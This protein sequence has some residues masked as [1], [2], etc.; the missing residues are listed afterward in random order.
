MLISRTALVLMGL[1]VGVS[2]QAQCDI[3]L[4]RA[5]FITC[6]SL[7]QQQ[8][9]GVYP[10]PSQ[11]QAPVLQA[12]QPLYQQPAPIYQQPAPLY[13]AP[14]AIYQPPAPIYQQPPIQ[15]VP[16]NRSSAYR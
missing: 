8:Q 5:Q 11:F 6:L 2:V 13:Q 14:P 7:L 1:G 4:P 3:T 16:S 10:H 9:T 15:W 12:P